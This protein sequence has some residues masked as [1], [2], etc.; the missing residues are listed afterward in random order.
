M[1]LSSHALRLLPLFITGALADFLGPTYPAP[2]DLT[3]DKSLI[4]A[5]WENLTSIFNAYLNKN[6]STASDS[7][8]GV[9][10]VTFSVGLFSIHDPAAAKL[11]YHY[12]SPEISNATQGTTK[13]DGDSIY[14]MASVSKLFTVFAGL[15]ELTNEDW[16]RSLTDVI[17]GLAH[18]ARETAGEGDPV[19]K[20]Q[21]GKITPWAL[22]AQIAGVPREGL[23]SADLLSPL[24]DGPDPVTTYGFPPLNVSK[25][26]PCWDL[27]LR[28]IN[29]PFCPADEFIA[30]VRSQP[31]SF[32]PWSTPGY[33]NNGFI[34]L[35]IAISKITGKSMATIYRESIF[36]PLG[37]TSSNSSP[38]TGKAELARSVIADDFAW[39]F[40]LKRG[41]TIPSGG[42]FSSINDLA[43]F[44]V[45][46]LNSTILPADLTRKWMKPITHTASLSYSVGAPWEI[47][48]YIHRSTGKITDLYTKLGDSGSYGGCLVLIPDYNAGF[49]ILDASTNTT[50]RGSVTN[51]I[52]D[53]ITELIL[54]ALEAQAA[55]EAA[56]NFV[57]KYVSTNS[58]LNSSVTVSLH[59]SSGLSISSWISN[60]TD[61]LASPLF[62]GE[63]PRLLPSIPNQSHGAGKVAFQASKN[64]QTNNY[65]SASNL[66]E[67]PFT[68][69]YAT[70][71]DWLLV[72]ATHYGGFGANLFVFE[73]EEGGNA[74]SVSPVV[75][76]AKL[77]RKA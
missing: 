40:A 32:L 7:L 42:L 50:L 25:L 66:G 23:A 48:R 18:F 71:S 22:A 26:G 34:L 10:K 64:P 59:K 46:I 76:R 5:S 27:S 53:H 47:V 60:G 38:P 70:N 69:H 36:E 15:L 4:P 28:D 29:S 20:V 35:G 68:A 12:T 21:W 52:L 73:V 14:I 37:M 33:A 55:A 3:S 51:R 13:V 49:S 65:T 75:T 57:G 63:K 72:D 16:N 44:G 74:T 54:P 67:G 17:P 9:E 45:G 19:Y 8:S 56:R 31:P 6:Q 39:E 30:D 58:N 11:Q 2:I 62:Q 43:K 1:H 41:D 77:E 24:L 61:V